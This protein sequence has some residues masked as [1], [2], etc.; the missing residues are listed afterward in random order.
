[1]SLFS[2]LLITIISLF[3]P[4]SGLFVF[5]EIKPQDKKKET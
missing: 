5:S 1:M 4:A 3:F 2:I